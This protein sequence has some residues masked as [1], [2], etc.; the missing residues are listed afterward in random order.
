VGRK[1]HNVGLI[2]AVLA[3]VLAINNA[4]WPIAPQS[5]VSFD[6][7]AIWIAVSFVVGVA[8]LVAAFLAEDHTGAAKVLLFSGGLVLVGSGIFF[9]SLEGI[10]AA[11][12]DL[13]PGVLAILAGFLVGPL[14]APSGTAGG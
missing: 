1:A 9:G 3:G 8:F 12:F 13:I 14:Y 6:L 5:Y 4:I 2:L 7:V 11:T 10:V